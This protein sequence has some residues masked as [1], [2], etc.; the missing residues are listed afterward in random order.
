MAD[1]RS[2]APAL[3]LGRPLTGKTTRLVEL[4]RALLQGG[5]SIEQILCLSFYSAN[6]ESIR[7]A[8]NSEQVEFFPGV[9]T[10]QRLQTLLLR[11]FAKAA[12]LPA[13]ARE[14]S[15][16]THALMTGQ[17]W[18]EVRGARDGVQAGQEAGTL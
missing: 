5:L 1:L 15:P 14:V 8:L 2:T 17:A 16:A 6:A 4:Y 18:A 13:R 9:T 11:D 10:L 12:N 3:L 7:R